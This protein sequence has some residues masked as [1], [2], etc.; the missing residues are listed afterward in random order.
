MKPLISVVIPTRNRSQLV[1]RAVQSALAQT[2]TAIEVIVVIDGS[3]P[4]TSAVLTEIDDP[5]SRVIELPVSGGAAAARNAGVTNAVAEWIAFLDDDDEWLP[6]K[7]ELQIATANSS[8]YPSPIVACR[9]IAHTPKGEFVWPRK[10][11]SPSQPLSE[12]LFAR[13]TLFQGE[14][15]LQTS[16]LLA[17]KDL[18]QTVPFS[19]DLQRHQEWDWL[20]RVNTLEDVGI[21]FVPQTLAVWYAE[22]KRIS[23]SAKNNWRYSLTWIRERRHLVTLR[24]YAAFVMTVVSM[25]AAREGDRQAFWTLLREAVQVGKPQPIDFL[26]YFGMWLIPQDTRRQLRA[27]LKRVEA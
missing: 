25:L 13:N 5:R 1:K 18:L 22:E 14:G 9:L 11:L 15:L 3:D 21:E 10:L 2:L 4:A 26:L 24:A 27:F 8:R 6:Q 19:S 20:L 7:L 12:Y 17:K 23:I 16:M